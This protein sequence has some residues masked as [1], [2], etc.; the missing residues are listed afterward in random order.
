M[1][2]QVDLA[3]HPLAGDRKGVGQVDDAERPAAALTGRFFWGQD[4]AVRALADVKPGAP[5]PEPRRNILCLGK[6]YLEHA[7]EVAK[8]MNVSGDA[9]AQP[10]IFTK[11]V[12]S[13]TGPYAEVTVDPGLTQEFDWEVELG[14]VICKTAKYVDEDKALD[15]VAGYCVINDVSERAFQLERSGQWVKGK[16]H[17]TYAPIGPWLV[18][19]EDVPN[20][21]KLNLWCDVNGERMQDG[22]TKNMI[23]P[24]KEIVSYVSKFMTLKPGDL[25]IRLDRKPISGSQQM[26]KIVSE[27]PPGDPLG[28]TLLRDGKEIEQVAIVAERPAL[29][30]R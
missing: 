16:S 26:L 22:T 7:Q 18:T 3:Q 13:V 11:A 21:Q 5:L 10:I 14:V 12:G 6:N 29:D 17:D 15:H 28:I 1:G 2:D 20:P 27:K 4:A 25:I 23:F 8:K 19:R 24:I 9:P 30:G